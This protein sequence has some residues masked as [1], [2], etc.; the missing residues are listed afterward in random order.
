MPQFHLDNF[1]PQLVWLAI[2]FAILYFGIVRLTLPKLGKTLTAR[3]DRI[4]GDL[5]TA[6]QAKGAAD[7]LSAAYAAG[8]D[9]AHKS[10]RTAIAEAKTRATE[11]VEKAVAAANAVLA[12]KAAAADVSLIG[13]R[14]RAMSEIEGVAADAAADIVERLTGRRPDAALVA[15][16]AKTAF[17]G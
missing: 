3:E 1:V 13:A 4:S 14:S 7:A 5:S 10:A 16:A 15:G 2:F 11:N 17:A 9:D 6:E 8:I 12:Q